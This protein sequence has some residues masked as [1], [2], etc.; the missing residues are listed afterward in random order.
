[1]RA[2]DV[3]G[4]DF[5]AWDRIGPGI[6]GEHQIVVPLI[7]VGPLG[8]LVDLDH[9]PPDGP[10]AVLQRRLVEQV[11]AAI[12]GHVVLVRVVR[13]VLP[14]FGEH[15]AVDLHLGVG[16]DQRHVLIHLGEPRAERADGPLQVPLAADVGLLMGEVPD[17]VVPVLQVDV[18][19]PGSLFDDQF[20]RR[21]SGARRHRHWCWPFRRAASLRRLVRGSREFC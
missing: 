14:T 20:D 13:K 12:G 21:R 15:H 2:A 16:A 7:G 9:A 17:L 19:Q 4:F 3:V 1:M 18:S 5:E 11:A 8:G 6:A 10:R